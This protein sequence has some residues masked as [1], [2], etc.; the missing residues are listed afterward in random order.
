MA[1]PIPTTSSSMNNP[2]SPSQQRG[3]TLIAP[4]EFISARLQGSLVESRIFAPHKG[5]TLR[6]RLFL[7][8]LPTTLLP[9]VIAGSLGFLAE[10]QRAQGEALSLLKEESFLAAHVA[11]DFVAEGFKVPGVVA[12]NP[13]IQRILK[14][15]GQL[16]EAERLATQ[17]TVSLETTFGDKKLFR[18]DPDLN[19]YLENLSRIELLGEL[20]VTE[21][22]GFNLAYSSPPPDFVQADE[23]WWQTAKRTGQHIG[24]PEIDRKTNHMAVAISQ[25]IT[26]PATK[27]F[28]GVIRT[29]VPTKVMDQRIATSIISSA[30]GASQAVQVV[31]ARTGIPFN[32]IDPK[33][34]S[35]GGAEIIGGSTIAS[36]AIALQEE[37]GNADK[38]LAERRIQLVQTSK[39]KSVQLQSQQ[40]TQGQEILTALASVGTKTYSL[41][42]VPQTDWIAIASVDISEVESAGN[43]LIKVFATTTVLLGLAATGVLLLLARQLSYPLN[44]LTGTAEAATAGNL[45]V[46]ADLQGTRETQTLGNVFNTLL[47][48][49]QGLLLEQ[50]NSA[51]EQQSLRQNLEQDITQ[52]ME[53][54]SEAAAGDLRVRATLSDGDV[55]IVA[56]LFNAIIENLRLTASKVKVSTGQ[57][58]SSLAINEAEIRELTDQAIA[59]AKTLK[60]TLTAVEDI[61]ESIQ[62]VA[63]NAGQAS[64]LTQDTYTSVQAGTAF[65]DETAGS[66]L[67]LRIT[68]SETAKKI[69][70]LGESA[71]KISQTVGL[72][73][74]IAL[75]TNLLAVNA[76]VEAARAGELGQG[77]T[78]VA[79]QVGALAEQSSKAT[80][81]IAQ[82]VAAIQTETQEVVQAIEMGT[83][84]VVDSTNLVAA[85]KQNLS[86]ILG[87]SKQI[88]QLM[89]KIA[90][91][92]IYQTESSSAVTGLVQRVAQE[93][94]QRSASSSQMA[95]A[96]Q[97]TAQVA[98][99]LEASVEQFKLA[100][101]EPAS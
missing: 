60:E 98:R 58:T 99:E 22:H 38:S 5:T 32:L 36:L 18:E 89:K 76:S 51:I 67:G 95:Q 37:L 85:T 97:V 64:Q 24:S 80:K 84:Q 46:R 28:L 35:S 91:A 27:A 30:V 29:L 43:D 88:N 63:A 68:V 26:D 100:D 14:D 31:D 83:A 4:L 81:E 74:E 21:K 66:I 33:G 25:A 20:S 69:K 17:P 40:P 55:G 19:Q 73:D 86:E 75:K 48:Q 57:V 41:T 9:L 82:I 94:E 93:S 96:I 56:D 49:I 12:I 11:A 90:E 72:I 8:L 78:A 16:A 6:Q 79:E 62:E 13:S 92:A 54:I 7:T 23:R 10:K 77:F 42:T 34:V 3:K 71:Q 1:A 87:K 2:L 52:L 65:M 39:I 50:K 61:A 47:D 45:D 101:P 59:E 53:D 15:N 44:A 70:R